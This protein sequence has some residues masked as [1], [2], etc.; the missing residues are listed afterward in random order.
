[1]ALKKLMNG[2]HFTKGLNQ[3][4]DK[5]N[6]SGTTA[7]FG[8]DILKAE[9]QDCENFRFDRTGRLDKRL[10]FKQQGNVVP[11]MAGG[12]DG[13]ISKGVALTH[14]GDELI[15][16]DGSKA[17]S[18]TNDEK[19][20]DRG[21]VLNIRAKSERVASNAQATSTK[22]SFGINGNYEI[23]AWAEQPNASFTDI[24]NLKHL[25]DVAS[26]MRVKY[27]IRDRQTGAM[28]IPATVLDVYKPIGPALN[29]TVSGSATGDDLTGG[30]TAFLSQLGTDYWVE[31]SD[32]STK[33][34]RHR[35]LTLTDD[36]NA[37][38]AS[39]TDGTGANANFG[40]TF[41][42]TTA[43][44]VHTQS[45]YSQYFTPRPQVVSIPGTNHVFI[46]SAIG[47]E[48]HY[49]YIDTTGGTDSNLTAVSKG[50]IGASMSWQHPQFVA[51]YWLT[52]EA[53][54][55]ADGAEIVTLRNFANAAFT[56]ERVFIESWE[57]D[58]S[59]GASRGD[60]TL[61]DQTDWI[62][63][64]S[65]GNY[66]PGYPSGLSEAVSGQFSM[67]VLHSLDS[68]GK[69]EKSALNQVIVVGPVEDG[70]SGYDTKIFLFNYQLALT[71]ETGDSYTLGG[72]VPQL[73]SGS[74]HQRSGFAFDADTV[75]IMSEIRETGNFDPSKSGERDLRNDPRSYLVSTAISRAHPFT[76]QYSRHL[77][78]QTSVVSDG[79]VSDGVPYFWVSHASSTDR[80]TVTTSLIDYRGRVHANGRVGGGCVNPAV[81]YPSIVNDGAARA[82][83]GMPSINLSAQVA[84]V[85]PVGYWDTGSTEFVAGC[86]EVDLGANIFAELVNTVAIGDSKVPTE[87]IWSL[88]SVI[89]FDTSPARPL[90][91]V[92]AGDGVFTAGGLLWSYDGQEFIENNFIDIPFLTVSESDAAAGTGSITEDG[93]YSYFAVYE[94]TDANGYVHQSA[95]SK[96]VNQTITGSSTAMAELKIWVPQITNMRDWGNGDGPVKAAISIYRSSSRAVEEA[97]FFHGSVSV[98]TYGYYYDASKVSFA[99][100]DYFVYF[101][102]RS[103][104]TLTDYTLADTP[105]R[106]AIPY[107]SNLALHR[108]HLMVGTTRDKVYSSFLFDPAGVSAPQFDA[109]SAISPEGVPK[110]IHHVVSTGTQFVFFTKDDAFSVAGEGPGVNSIG[111]FMPPSLFIRG[112]GTKKDG[113]AAMTP[114]GL[115]FTT[116]AGIYGAGTSAGLN[117]L[118]EGIEN[119]KGL[120][121]KGDPIVLAETNEVIIPV[122]G[123]VALVYN[124]YFKLWHTLL[125]G[126]DSNYGEQVEWTGWIDKNGQTQ[127]YRLDS[128]GRVY[129]QKL[130]TDS[131]P[132]ADTIDSD[133]TNYTCSA[134]TSWM[135]FPKEAG[136][137]RLYRV[138]LQGEF[139]ASDTAASVTMKIYKDFD[140]SSSDSYVASSI[141]PSSPI[142]TEPSEIVLKP[143]TQKVKAAQIEVLMTSTSAGKG[144]SLSGLQFEIGVK[145][146]KTYFKGNVG[147]V[148]APS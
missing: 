24:Q 101:Y 68:D 103:D 39:T 5:K 84:R 62:T 67:K 59:A 81:E 86:S 124:Y 109:S 69:P 106:A 18:Q 126:D 45:I 118:G 35:L 30:S 104:T 26:D 110:E 85:T 44:P 95:P 88:P 42:G 75:F 100:R 29:G 6:Q 82:V 58:D 89:R 76:L 63:D 74:V 65:D 11:D 115:M 113:I 8:Q 33:M 12:S 130:T 137:M 129:R 78:M 107:P 3:K 131:Q 92:Q 17:Y 133:H 70:G 80:T 122:S 43:Y 15:L 147:R 72:V 94:Y 141:T 31:V 66:T 7:A 135:Q 47:H 21:D 10:G 102:D 46:F 23:T 119:L 145:K 32:G 114:A 144:Y 4:P 120:P 139:D 13:A 97:F 132:Y 27:S 99:P 61:R 143:K 57:I 134:K 116:Q 40:F 91:S 90:R 48:I 2:F 28:I 41:S 9:L 138:M 36:T 50:S 16:F 93:I 111:G 127:I 20:V 56:T 51:D 25:P 83:G 38:V 55:D 54:D 96:S 77:Q 49:W 73:P 142:V 37:I 71:A 34:E 60:L 108:D 125:I 14:R 105:S 53:T 22:A 121:N 136:L 140:E 79:F 98:P 87:M 64:V 112:Q 123:D 52:T 1:M 117:Y 146:P 19:W 148:I 128:G